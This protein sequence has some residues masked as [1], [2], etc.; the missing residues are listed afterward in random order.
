MNIETLSVGL[1]LQQT[2]EQAAVQVQRMALDTAQEQGAALTKMLESVGIITDPNLGNQ[3]D[4]L[5]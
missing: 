5:A 2:Q 3:V 1:A 4:L